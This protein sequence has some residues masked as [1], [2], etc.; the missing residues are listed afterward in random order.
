M[1]VRG[2]A[3]LGSEDAAPSHRRPDPRGHGADLGLQRHGHALRPHPRFPAPRLRC[4]PVRGGGIAGGQRDAVP[5]A[6]AVGRRPA[7]PAPD[8]PRRGIPADQP[9]L[10]RLRVEAE[11]GDDGSADHGDDSDL[12]GH[13]RVARRAGAADA[14][15]L[16]RDRGRIR[17]R[18]ARRTGLGRRYLVRPRRRPARARALGVLGLLLG[19]DRT[20]DAALLPVSDQ[21]R[22]ALR[23]VCSVRGAELSADRLPGLQLAQ[24][25]DLGLP[26]VRDRRPTLP[27]EPALVHG[28]PPRRTGPG[29]AVRQR[30]AVR[31][32][33]VRVP[34][35]LGA[36]AL[37]RGRR[38]VNDPGGDRPR[39]ILA[40]R[41]GS[42]AG[43]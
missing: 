17:G 10:V 34:D 30:A 7:E 23:D 19:P 35:P 39:A 3:S 32:R 8:R 36:P 28:R 37:A 33:S 42:G 22:R 18:C 15:V 43:E 12:H 38:R 11:L 41:T 9:D 1:V 29:D 26:R 24:P 13:R 6:V 2:A 21:R 25:P 31:C 20:A 4:A 16:D 14:P 27:D 40:P 5:R